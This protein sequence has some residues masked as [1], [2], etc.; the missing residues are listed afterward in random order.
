MDP[1]SRAAFLIL[2]LA[3]AAHSVEEYVSGL[4]EVF[5]P[6]RFLSG[7][8]GNNL[9]AGFAI[10]NAGLIVFGFWCYFARVRPGYPSARAFAWFW[11]VLEFTNG[12][13]HSVL[14]ASRA[15][16]FPGV[17]TAPALLGISGYLAAKLSSATRPS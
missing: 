8:V 12:L 2:I 7:L 16:Y 17:A 3:Q 4:F 10:I 6:A 14:A 5:G 11:A 15:D 13:G 1:R 9:A